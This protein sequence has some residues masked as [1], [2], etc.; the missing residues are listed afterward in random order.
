MTTILTNSSVYLGTNLYGKVDKFT[1]PD[2]EVNTVEMKQGYGTYKLPVGINPLTVSFDLTCLDKTVYS[3]IS[4]PFNEVNLT[5]YGSLSTFN[6]ET[7]T[8]EQ[9][10]K[11]IMRGSLGKKSLLG[12][13][14]QQENSTIAIEMNISSFKLIV[15]GETWEHLDI[16]NVIWTVNGKDML[17]NLKKNLGL[18]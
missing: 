3:K 7:L 15:A 1:T 2:V 4:N 6:N 8:K 14:K 16:P 12:E 11:L 13:L 9:Q 17:A 5:V 10:A 18:S